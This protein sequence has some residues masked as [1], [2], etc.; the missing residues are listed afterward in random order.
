MPRYEITKFFSNSGSRNE[1][2]M[3]VVD[4]L[5]A[6]TPGTGNG[7][8][9]SKYIY[10]VETLNSGDR[11]YLQR[12]ANLHNGFDFV[13]VENANYLCRGSEEGTSQARRLGC[14]FT[15]KRPKTKKCTL[16]FTDC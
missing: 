11:V 5:A 7:E 3:R 6:E 16:A 15:S 8:D 9:A 14:G 13:C 2:R 1:V 12:P 10:Y 4:A